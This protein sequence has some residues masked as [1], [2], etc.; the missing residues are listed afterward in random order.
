MQN[1]QDVKN[2]PFGF[3]EL[4]PYAKFFTGTTYLKNLTSENA[5]KASVAQV[6][7]EPG[8]INHWH[9]HNV[10]QILIGTAGEGWVQ[11]EGEEPIKMTEGTVVVIEPNT[12]H[13]HGAAKD[14]WFSHLSVIVGEGTTDWQEPVDQ[15][16]YQNL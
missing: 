1:E 16:F 9:S 5:G 7:F 3:G 2:S 13:W 6:T 14:S 12:R 11:K 8:V 4:N 10:T 15:T